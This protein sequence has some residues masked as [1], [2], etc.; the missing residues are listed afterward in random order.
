MEK[1][2][3]FHQVSKR[4]TSEVLAVNQLSFEV[5]SC[6]IF[7][8][9]GPNGSGKTTTI[10]LILGLIQ[11]SAGEV[12]VMGMAPE[13]LAIKYRIGYQP[14]ES[15]F[16]PFL[17]S[18]EILRFYGQIYGIPRKTLKKRMDYLLDLVGLKNKD[19][20]RKIGEYSKGMVRR[21]GL[22]Q[23]LLNDPSLL[24]L[25]EPTSGMDPIGSREFKDLLL[26][27]KEEGKTIL[28]SSHLLSDV[29]MTCDEVMIL[30]NGQ[31]VKR[32]HVKDLLAS[33]DT[34]EALFR[35][36]TPQFQEKLKALAKEEGV[37][38]LQIGP[39]ADSLENV[40]LKALGVSKDAHSSSGENNL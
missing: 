38:L 29:A 15:Y 16:Y 28:L 17:N 1:M 27:L 31:E 24:I 39:Y 4:Y 3:A 37:E 40:F 5:N 8:L 13:T 25:D 19:R 35:S 18:Y 9:V 21:I 33:E 12:E 14:E 7:G 36:L 6:E 30:H 34:F 11:P 23:A 26:R 20:K 10:K 32:G 22:A 2:I